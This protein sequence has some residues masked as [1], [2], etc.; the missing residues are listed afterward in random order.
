M[1]VNPCPARPVIN[2]GSNA[3]AVNN[4]GQLLTIDIEGKPRVIY[5]M[6]DIG[7][8]EYDRFVLNA[9][10]PYFGN[11]GSSISLD[12]SATLTQIVKSFP[13]TGIS[14]TMGNMTTLAKL[15]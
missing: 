11:E 1:R 2:V 9:G 8:Y 4:F 14:I 10:G 3:L 13:M 5:D 15:S 12:A 6:V 7:A